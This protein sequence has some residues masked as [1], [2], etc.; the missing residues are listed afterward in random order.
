MRCEIRKTDEF[1]FPLLLRAVTGTFILWGV[2]CQL[3]DSYQRPSREHTT[4]SLPVWRLQMSQLFRTH[5]LAS[6]S[7]VLAGPVPRVC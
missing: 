1:V 7:Q 4:V 2:E 5:Q 6:R 3:F